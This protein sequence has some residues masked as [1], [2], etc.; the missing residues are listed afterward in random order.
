MNEN[1][2]TPNELAVIALCKEYCE[3]MARADG[4]I[5]TGEFVAQLCKLLPRIYICA[6]DLPADDTADD[7]IPMALDEITYDT[8]RATIAALIGENDTYLDVFVEDMKYSESP[9]L[10]TISENLADLYQEFY[11]FLAA[12]AF[13]TTEEQHRLTGALRA[14]FTARWAQTLCNVM[15]PLNDLSLTSIS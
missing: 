10:C 7:D 6:N 15:R 14:R 1:T 9:I 2:L 5:P 4:T 8:V 3:L 11:D 12:A 13:A